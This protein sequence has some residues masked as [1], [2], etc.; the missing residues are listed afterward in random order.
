MQWT[1]GQRAAIEARN[2]SVLVSAAAGSGKEHLRR[3]SAHGTLAPSVSQ[4]MI[5]WYRMYDPGATLEEIQNYE[6]KYRKTR[7]NQ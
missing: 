3:S 6:K 2:F 4:E 1:E 7:G 5:D